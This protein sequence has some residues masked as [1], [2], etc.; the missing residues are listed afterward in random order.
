MDFDAP[1]LSNC[2]STEKQGSERIWRN[3]RSLSPPSLACKDSALT[4]E[5]LCNTQSWI[6]FVYLL[7]LL[8]WGNNF[9]NYPDAVRSSSYIHMFVDAIPSRS[10]ANT[11]DT[12]RGG[13]TKAND[14]TNGAVRNGKKSFVSTYW[15]KGNLT[16]TPWLY[17]H[18]AILEQ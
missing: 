7:A 17:I 14:R 10:R 12:P 2:R 13:A 4:F 15:E 1:N 6:E 18:F 5:P 8:L 11:L 3:R 16:L 9:K